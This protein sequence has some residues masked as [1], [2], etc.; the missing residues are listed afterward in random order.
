V[1]IDE[2]DIERKRNAA[3][4]TTL[5]QSEI[6]AIKAHGGPYDAQSYFTHARLERAKHERRMKFLLMSAIIAVGLCAFAFL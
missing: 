5:K 1:I 4:E 6:D 3:K 2:R